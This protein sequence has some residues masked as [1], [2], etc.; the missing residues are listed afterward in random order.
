MMM[1]PVC[2]HDPGGGSIGDATGVQ[3]GDGGANPSLRSVSFP[4]VTTSYTLY[5]P[6]MGTA[7]RTSV[8]AARFFRHPNVH[9]KLM[10]PYGAFKVT[11]DYDEYKALYVARLNEHADAILAELRRL[12][13]PTEGRAALLCFCNLSKGWCHRRILAE[14]FGERHGLSIPEWGTEPGVDVPLFDA[15]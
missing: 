13:E 3:P 12:A 7:I 8:G 2:E 15:P 1:T 4:V 9:S 5:R 10:S 14:W 6:D 11:E